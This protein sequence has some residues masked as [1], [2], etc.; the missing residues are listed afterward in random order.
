MPATRAELVELH[1]VR[2]VA[3]ILLRVVG[4]LTAF[5]ASKVNQNADV[6]AFLCHDVSLLHA[7]DDPGS[8]GPATLADREA[9]LLLHR[10]RHDQL[11]LHRYV[12]ARHHHLYAVG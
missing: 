4:P 12:V 3:P 11:H 9:K 2:V 8:H 7:G 5:G 6:A 10:D 1:P